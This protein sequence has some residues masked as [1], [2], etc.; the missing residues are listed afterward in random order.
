MV[1][2]LSRTVNT[3]RVVW[4]FTELASIAALLAIEHPQIIVEAA[5]KAVKDK[6]ILFKVFIAFSPPPL[7]LR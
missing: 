4:K 3:P 7:S 5:T 6:A 2:K 1:A